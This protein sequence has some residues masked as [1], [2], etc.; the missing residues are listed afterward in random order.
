METKYHCV[1]VRQEL[2]AS[3]RSVNALSMCPLLNA[4]INV[5]MYWHA[6]MQFISVWWSCSSSI[7]TTSTYLTINVSVVSVKHRD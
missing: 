3:Q 6:S 5:T 4:V 2:K 7:Y 1:I